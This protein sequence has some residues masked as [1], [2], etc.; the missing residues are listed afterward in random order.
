MKDSERVFT[1]G[2]E[3]YLEFRRT[4]LIIGLDD[5]TKKKIKKIA[6]SLPKDA[7]DVEAEKP[8]IAINDKLINKLRDA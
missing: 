5:L 8:R 1:L 3:L 2:S 7:N 6:L 4:R